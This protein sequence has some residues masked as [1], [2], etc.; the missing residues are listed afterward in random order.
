MGAL[1]EGEMHAYHL[2]RVQAMAPDSYLPLLNFAHSY[3]EQTAFNRTFP[4]GVSFTD[5]VNFRRWSMLNVHNSHLWGH[6]DP[7]D[8]YVRCV[9]EIKN[10]TSEA[11]LY[12]AFTNALLAQ[13]DITLT[14]SY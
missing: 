10:L 2:Q 9:R 3:L 13:R 5:E 8:K 11:L 14:H 1:L 6:D 4:A 7:Y 12:F